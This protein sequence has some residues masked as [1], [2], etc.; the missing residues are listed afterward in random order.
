LALLLCSSYYHWSGAPDRKLHFPGDRPCCGLR[1]FGSKRAPAL[2]NKQQGK[3]SMKF[4]G[5]KNYVATDDLKIAVN[6]SI[7]LERC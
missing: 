4:T 3:G 6:A 1:L 5:T 2:K 7:V